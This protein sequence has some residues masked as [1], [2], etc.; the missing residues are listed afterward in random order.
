[1]SYQQY[2]IIFIDWQSPKI[3][4]VKIYCKKIQPANCLI[5]GDAARQLNKLPIPVLHWA[6][7]QRP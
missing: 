6:S 3:S 7:K 2:V 4:G 1:M 5:F